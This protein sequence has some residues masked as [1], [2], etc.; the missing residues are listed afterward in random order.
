MIPQKLNKKIKRP[1]AFSSLG[2][3][4][5]RTEKKRIYCRALTVLA[6]SGAALLSNKSGILLEAR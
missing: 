4:K 2:Q 3:K 1:H 6:D 5:K